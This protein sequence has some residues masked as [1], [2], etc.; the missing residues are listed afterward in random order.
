MQHYTNTELE[1]LKSYMMIHHPNDIGEYGKI[2]WLHVHSDN[3]DHFKST[4]TI[5]YF[6]TLIDRHG[7]ARKT[8]YNYTFGNM[9]RNQLAAN[10]TVRDCVMYDDNGTDTEPVWLERFMYNAELGGQ[11]RNVNDTGNMIE[12]MGL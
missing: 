3:A 6:T 8:A 5:H 4:G 7:R 9:D 11:G 2:V 10:L 12:L 1:F